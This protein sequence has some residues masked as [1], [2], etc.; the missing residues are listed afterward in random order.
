[1]TI[2]G[3]V[4]RHFC[5]NSKPLLIGLTT[6]LGRGTIGGGRQKLQTNWAPF[7]GSLQSGKLSGDGLFPLSAS[8]GEFG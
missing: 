2:A 8:R 6:G 7:T 5:L 4:A 1:L 3:L